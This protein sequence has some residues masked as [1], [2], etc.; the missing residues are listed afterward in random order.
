M[1]RYYKKEDIFYL[2]SYIILFLFAIRFLNKNNTFLLVYAA[3]GICL[4]ITHRYLIL[5]KECIVLLLYGLFYY[6]TKV[7]WG[8]EDNLTSFVTLAVGA[9]LMYMAGQQFVHFSTDKV[10]EYKT[11][12]WIISIGMFL[13]A[14]LSY[15]KNGVVYNYKDGQD[16]RQIPD[17]WVGNASLWQATNINGYTVFAII[18][19]MICFFQKK[20]RK[21]ILLA[22]ILLVG[23]LYLTLIT[24]ARTNLFLIVL[25]IISYVVLTLLLRQN[26]RF[27][28]RKH[29]LSKVFMA[30]LGLILAQIVILNLDSL[31]RHLPLG[32]F[33]ERLN[34]RQLSISSDGR[35]EM[36]A[37]V[38]QEIPT[39]FWG[40]ITSVYAAHNI[41]LDVARESGVIPMILLLIF[42]IMLLVTAWKLLWDKRYPLDL[43]MLNGVLIFSL[44][45][46]F[47]IEPVMGAKP[48]VFISF[49]MV[50]GMQK[51]LSGGRTYGKKPF[52]E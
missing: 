47:L 39:H 10:R 1:K 9:P 23:S 18:L 13:F 21:K 37:N 36:W 35:W 11:I 46:S 49:C 40:N 41:Y 6:Y 7:Y 3:L 30:I 28:S 19:S 52:E 45:G 48:F 22:F 14:I 8:S 26:F 38:L 51:E 27:I 34:N 50:C 16:L 29:T 2:I 5:S 25:I 43:R 20:E 42:T 24:A 32:A 33:M 31:L 17:F 15:F 12:C 4:A 44:W